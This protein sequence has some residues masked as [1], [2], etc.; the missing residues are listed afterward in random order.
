MFIRTD[1]G[2]VWG[3]ILIICSIMFFAP[4]RTLQ[5]AADCNIHP[6]DLLILM[7]GRTP[8]ASEPQL[9]LAR[10]FHALAAVLQGLQTAAS[11]RSSDFALPADQIDGWSGED[12]DWVDGRDF[13]QQAR[14]PSEA[15]SS[16]LADS[17]SDEDSRFAVSFARSKPMDHQLLVSLIA[18]GVW[19]G[20]IA[21]AEQ[22]KTGLQGVCTGPCGREFAYL[23]ILVWVHTYAFVAADSKVDRS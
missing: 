7:E 10:L 14:T 22:R 8:S 11:Q 5:S 21:S 23:V 17:F 4:F 18:E 6:T 1:S 15:E 16:S 9:V 19:S 3:S 13:A 2:L 12:D 20:A